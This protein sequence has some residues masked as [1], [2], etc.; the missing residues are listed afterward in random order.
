MWYPRGQ[1]RPS[2]GGGGPA[3]SGL[4]A[5]SALELLAVQLDNDQL[6]ALLGVLSPDPGRDPAPV[7]R[8]LAALVTHLRRIVT[9]QSNDPE[10]HVEE[11]LLNYLAAIGFQRTSG[12]LSQLRSDWTH[13]MFLLDEKCCGVWR[14]VAR[15]EVQEVENEA[16]EEIAA[17]EMHTRE[18]FEQ[19]AQAE[20]SVNEAR[21]LESA[22]GA[23]ARSENAAAAARMDEYVAR[24]TT[25]TTVSHRQSEALRDAQHLAYRQASEAQQQLQQLSENS[26]RF[27]L[28]CRHIE[29]VEERDLDRRERT[30]QI[31]Q[32]V[33]EVMQQW[34][35]GAKTKG[36]LEEHLEHASADSLCREQVLQVNAQAARE[37][38]SELDKAMFV[39]R[40]A[41]AELAASRA[42][43]LNVRESLAVTEATCAAE[44]RSLLRSSEA[45]LSDFVSSSDHSTCSRKQ[46]HLD[47]RQRTR[48]AH[49]EIAVWKQELYLAGDGK[50]AC[51]LLPAC[52]PCGRSTRSAPGQGSCLHSRPTPDLRISLAALRRKIPSG[53]AAGANGTWCVSDCVG[54]V[55]GAR[56]GCSGWLG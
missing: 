2:T 11:D 55:E 5:E 54:S 44:V 32:N 39:A 35:E 36:L 1:S 45:Q 20:V 13:R 56:G 4:A 53:K 19:L 9:L 25:A 17:A 24:V 43:R 41:Q 47:H 31:R 37:L 3:S 12:L 28:V 29:F 51:G 38:R 23:A 40:K 30:S 42:F 10:Q 7:D 33:A 15:G 48:R 27:G 22:S 8:L 16:R 46:S 50:V 26:Q 14:S 52:H 34:A 6:W 21:Q 49:D 18:V